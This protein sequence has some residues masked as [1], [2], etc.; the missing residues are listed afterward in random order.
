MTGSFGLRLPPAVSV[1]LFDVR[2]TVAMPTGK[3]RPRLRG[4]CRGGRQRG[5]S[6]T[7]QC[8]DQPENV[9]GHVELAFLR[10]VATVDLPSGKRSIYQ[11]WGT[12]ADI[13]RAVT[14]K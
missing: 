10:A 2:V 8:F 13:I 4:G 3:L 9:L 11:I 7:H 6:L 5:P 1:R 14:T 12:H